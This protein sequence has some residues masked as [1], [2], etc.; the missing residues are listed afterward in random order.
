MRTLTFSLRSLAFALFAAERAIRSL[1]RHLTTL[2]SM[3]LQKPKNLPK[4]FCKK[5]L[6]KLFLAINFITYFLVTIF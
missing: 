5:W 6:Y 4:L 1:F 3:E 2:L